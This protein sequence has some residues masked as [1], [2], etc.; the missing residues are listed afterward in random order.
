MPVSE[1]ITFLLF[2]S[3]VGCVYIIEAI[4]LIR[5]G[6]YKSKGQRGRKVLLSKPAI[7]LHAISILGLLCLLYGR[8]IEPT[9]VQLNTFEIQ[10]PKL[11]NASFRIVHITDMHCDKKPLNEQRMVSIVNSLAPDVIVFTGDAANITKGVPLFKKTLSAMNTGLARLAVRGN[12]E[13]RHRRGPELYSDTGFRLLDQDTVKIEKEGETIYISG[14]TCDKPDGFKPLIN[15]V[16]QEHYS[17]FLHHWSDL[18]EDIG[19]A[20]VD[21]YLCGH[22]HGGQIALPLYG[23]VITLSKFGKK[24]EAGLYTVGK[25]TM[26]VNRG[27]GLEKSPAPKVRF[28][29]RPEIAVFDIQPKR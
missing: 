27:I 8:F 23:A 15:G 6:L 3:I 19:A 21:L 20:N 29:A 12:F 17:I 28:F 26:Y 24:Y 1:L 4:L 5:F 22:T 25:T 2:L 18:I 9:W 10:T 16:P 13:T 7:A 14:L 11:K